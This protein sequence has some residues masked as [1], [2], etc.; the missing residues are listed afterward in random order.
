MSFNSMAT[1]WNPNNDPWRTTD[2]NLTLTH[3]FP[4]DPDLA[5]LWATLSRTALEPA[6][7]FEGADLHDMGMNGMGMEGMESFAQGCA[8][9]AIIR[10]NPIN[11]TEPL[12]A[13]EIR[14]DRNMG[15]TLVTH[16]EA[17]RNRQE[18]ELE[19]REERELQEAMWRSAADRGGASQFASPSPQ[20]STSQQTRQREWGLSTKSE[21]EK[22]GVPFGKDEEDDLDAIWQSAPP[23]PSAKT[24]DDDELEN[25]LNSSDTSARAGSRPQWPNPFRSDEDENLNRTSAPSPPSWNTRLDAYL[26]S[27]LSPP[28]FRSPPIPSP[29]RSQPIG[30]IYLT[31]AAH[32]GAPA[33]EA[34]VGLV[35]AESARG[36][37]WGTQALDCVLRWA[38]EDAGVHRISASVVNSSEGDKDI[39]GNVVGDREVGGD[40][41]WAG[42]RLF[43]R[44]GFSVEGVRR[45]AVYVRGGWRDVRSLA[46]L[47][48]EWV[49]RPHPAVIKAA[50]GESGGAAS[51]WEEMF[52][53]HTRERDELLQWE[54]IREREQRKAKKRS[55]SVETLKREPV[56]TGQPENPTPGHAR[57]EGESPG[58]KRRLS[59]ASSV[60]SSSQ[61]ESSGTESWA[62]DMELE[63]DMGS[64]WEF[65]PPASE[66]QWES[67]SESGSGS[68]FD[69][70][71]SSADDE[72]DDELLL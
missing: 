3:A 15:D 42:L 31:L 10:A 72:S 4:P 11:P 8:L 45:R 57:E 60:P 33:G 38:V 51:L 18:K 17:L 16:Q 30:L 6:L 67:G 39:N 22:K 61:S 32:S 19:E 36:K 46:M 63:V 43:T 26:S 13:D 5:R 40:G 21:L 28:R 37:G 20:P 12:K 69:S 64:D 59:I 58:K 50:E 52:S 41:G 25:A 71:G 27:R 24:E 7:A 62:T 14:Q 54:E 70:L 35:L 2:V 55:S 29:P 48:T 65:G 68:G 56:T 34:Q 1:H 47:A 44:V 49:M 53:R 9:F 23:S 66:G